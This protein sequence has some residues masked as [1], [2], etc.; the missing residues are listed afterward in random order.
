MMKGV[1][2]KERDRKAECRH[3]DNNRLQFWG[4]PSCR[5]TQQRASEQFTSL[6][7][8]RTSNPT[9]RIAR[10]GGESSSGKAAQEKQKRK[11]IP[12]LE[13]KQHC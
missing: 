11:A 6:G 12:R 4:A 7:L 3:G 13:G 5:A 8:S 2:S 9:A 1:V 10:G